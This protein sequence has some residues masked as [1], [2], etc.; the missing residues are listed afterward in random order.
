M[1][2]RDGK[3]VYYRAGTS[4]ID[5]RLATSPSLRVLSRD[6]VVFRTGLFVGSG[7]LTGTDISRDGR[8][9]GLVTNKDDFQLVVVPNWRLELEKRLA[10]A[11]H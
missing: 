5:A 8:L 4:E 1:W 7:T 2:S 6:T 9:L 3:T 11:K 10:A